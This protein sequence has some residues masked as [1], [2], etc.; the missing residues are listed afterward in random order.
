M[1]NSPELTKK[2]VV[3][4]TSNKEVKETKIYL[5]DKAPKLD[6]SANAISSKDLGQKSQRRDVKLG[7]EKEER[8]LC[9]SERKGEVRDSRWKG[10]IRPMDLRL[11]ELHGLYSGRQDKRQRVNEFYNRNGESQEHTK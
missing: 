1:A 9:G 2:V 4:L 10:E 11:M 8:V 3:D 6:V 7:R 5:W